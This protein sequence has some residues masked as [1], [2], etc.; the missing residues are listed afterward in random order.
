MSTAAGSVALIWAQAN[1]GVIG[2]D[3]TMPWRLPEDLAHFRT[4]T[5]TDTVVM[6]RKTWESLPERF[7]PLPERAN[8]VV[9]RQ[10]GRVAPG[11]LVVHSLENALTA[12]PTETVWV[13]GGSEL[14]KLALDVA[15]RLEV[16][17]IDLHVEGDTF[18]PSV[19]GEQ[20]T[21]VDAD[22]E[23]RTSKTGLRYRFLTYLR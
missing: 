5:G 10:T 22:P 17:E 7:R 11:A 16:T 4:L 21:A 1:G 13:M 14:Y 9:T 8:V 6:G 2:K 20:W 23:W 18:A 15:D 12:S 19:D 3:G